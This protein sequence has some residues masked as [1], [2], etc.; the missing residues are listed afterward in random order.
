MAPEKV[1]IPQAAPAVPNVEAPAVPEV[2]PV[3]PLSVPVNSAGGDLTLA[4]SISFIRNAIW[5]REMC[6]AVA[7]GDPGCVW[8]ILKV[9]EKLC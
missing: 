3:E 7:E 5:W 4:N 1:A 6:R 9:Y 8:E 2:E